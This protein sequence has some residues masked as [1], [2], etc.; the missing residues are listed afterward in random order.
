MMESDIHIALRGHGNVNGSVLSACDGR[1]SDLLCFLKGVLLETTMEVMICSGCS[2]L[3]DDPA[4]DE[5]MSEEED[6]LDVGGV[7][8]E[9]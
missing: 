9:D 3:L 6:G 4:P 7:G 5:G 8:S 1:I 2:K